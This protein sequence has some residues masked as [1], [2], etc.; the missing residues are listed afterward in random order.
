MVFIVLSLSLYPIAWLG[1]KLGQGLSEE[2]QK[3]EDF[4][5]YWWRKM[6]KTSRYC[7][8]CYQQAKSKKAKP[9]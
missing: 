1:Y 6:S 9:L 3:G 8:N 5:I 4:C 2:M 7:Y